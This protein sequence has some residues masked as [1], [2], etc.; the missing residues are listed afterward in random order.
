MWK[1]FSGD[2]RASGRRSADERHIDF[3]IFWCDDRNLSTINGLKIN[4]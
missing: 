4:K 3:E 2:G 1:V